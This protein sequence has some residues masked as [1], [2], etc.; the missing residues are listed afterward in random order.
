MYR[1]LTPCRAKRG[2]GP[3]Q[4]NRH[5]WGF[6]GTLSDRPI[7]MSG[8]SFRSD[9]RCRLMREKKVGNRKRTYD[10]IKRSRTTGNMLCIYVLEIGLSQEKAKASLEWQQGK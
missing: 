1:H 6:P 3:L 10:L 5:E 8:A 2:T 7:I 9:R 4:P